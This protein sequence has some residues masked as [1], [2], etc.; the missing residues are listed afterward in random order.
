MQ[1][2]VNLVDLIKSFLTSIYL[3]ESASTQ[4]RSV[5]SKFEGDSIHFFIRLF[6]CRPRFHSTKCQRPAGLPPVSNDFNIR[7]TE[8]R[9]RMSEN[10]IDKRKT[11]DDSKRSARREFYSQKRQHPA[12]LP[13]VSNFQYTY[14]TIN[15]NLFQY[16]ILQIISIYIHSNDNTENIVY[17]SRLKNAAT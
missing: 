13:L 12:S 8:K 7:A 4:P 5:H 1:K 16:N 14:N 2:Y 11:A 15:S 9:G 10:V 6:K 17:S 3:Q